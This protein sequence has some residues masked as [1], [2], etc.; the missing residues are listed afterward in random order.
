M[1]NDEIK[2][3]KQNNTSRVNLRYHEK[4]ATQIIRSRQFHKKQI[5]KNNNGKFSI[6]QM[7]N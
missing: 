2:K 5:E 7:C 4:L 3:K 6:I 1:L